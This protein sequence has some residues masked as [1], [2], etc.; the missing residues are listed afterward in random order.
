MYFGT[1]IKILNITS[2]FIDIL[3]YFNSIDDFFYFRMTKIFI[4]SKLL[5][6]KKIKP[7]FSR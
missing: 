5:M 3:G 4:F 7:L 2:N 6:A 1:S